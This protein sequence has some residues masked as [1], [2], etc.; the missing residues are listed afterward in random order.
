MGVVTT[1]GCDVETFWLALQRGEVG[2]HELEHFDT[3]MLATHRGGE[4]TGLRDLRDE[5]TAPPLALEL[6]TTTA[7]SAAQDARLAG[8]G[9]EPDRVGVV[10]G[11]VMGTRP[12]VERWLANPQTQTGGDLTWTSSAALSRAAAS[13]LGF[14]GPNCVISTACASGNSAISFAAD[15]LLSG[16]ADAM[17][18][19]GSDELSHAMLMMFD[20]LRALSPDVVRPFDTNRRGLMLAEGAA[21]LV[22]ER[23]SDAVARKAPIY[24]RVAG[25]SNVADAHHITA[26]HPK[27]DGATRSIRA[28][29]AQAGASAHDVDYVCAHGTGTPSNDIVEATAIHSV[30]GTHT[31]HTP[32]S[33][34]KGALGH[35]QGA[36]S[37]IEA[38]CCLLAMRD[39]IVPLT[40]NCDTPDPTC[41]LDIVTRRPRAAKLRLVLSN[42]FGF[43]GNVECI[44]LGQAP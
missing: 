40:A 11:T 22:L 37:T 4:L 44:A 19:G 20:S 25:W 33:S 23:E 36:A 31:T 2:T 28:A 3:S 29:L 24:G 15:A 17:I 39:G 14:G 13:R 38:L 26:P 35:A 6:A 12:V 21:A 1:L 34:L 8:S 41:D 27:G 42:A 10:F 9:I 16:Q 7:T 43:G 32:V 30:F 18:A 5:F